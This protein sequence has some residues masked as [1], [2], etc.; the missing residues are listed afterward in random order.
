[1]TPGSTVTTASVHQAEVHSPLISAAT[2]WPSPPRKWAALQGTLSSK[3]KSEGCEEGKKLRF[4]ERE[5]FGA[6]PWIH[7]PTPP[8]IFIPWARSLPSPRVVWSSRNAVVTGWA[9]VLREFHTWGCL[10]LGQVPSPPEPDLGGPAFRDQKS[11]H[12]FFL[13]LAA[14]IDGGL[15]EVRGKHAECPGVTRSEVENCPN[16]QG[17][18]MQ[19]AREGLN[20]AV[21]HRQG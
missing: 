4:R 15:P 21:A 3:V 5:G 11:S 18:A 12:D 1:M 9:E 7:M 10:L 16:V 2:S 20:R 13:H 17:V 6:D 8:L 19:A 14:E